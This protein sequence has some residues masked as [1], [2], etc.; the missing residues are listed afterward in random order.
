MLLIKNPPPSPRS[1][2]DADTDDS[3]REWLSQMPAKTIACTQDQYKSNAVRGHQVCHCRQVIHGVQKF[4][5]EVHE[6][7]WPGFGN[8]P[9]KLADER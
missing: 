7:E 5:L 8:L 9:F 1:E 6:P 3:C 2:S 4:I